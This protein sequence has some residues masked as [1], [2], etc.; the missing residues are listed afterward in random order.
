MQNNVEVLWRLHAW[1]MSRFQTDR[2]FMVLH[3]ASEKQPI[4][5]PIDIQRY[6]MTQRKR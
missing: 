6:F 5:A 1:L 2:S 3:S 4:S